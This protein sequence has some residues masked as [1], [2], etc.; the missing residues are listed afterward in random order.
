MLPNSFKMTTCKKCGTVYVAVPRKWAEAEIASS[1]K[2]ISEMTPAYQKKHG[3]YTPP[4]LAQYEY[5]WCKNHYKNFRA[6]KKGD[7]PIGCTL[8]TIIKRRD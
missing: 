1:I 4:T 5:C 8:S 3:P 7:S 2:W 6:W